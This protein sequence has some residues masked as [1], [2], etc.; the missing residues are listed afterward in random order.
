MEVLLKSGSDV[1]AVDNLGHDAYHYARHCKNAEVVAMVKSCLDKANRGPL[2]FTFSVFSHKDRKAFCIVKD[3]HCPV[4]SVCTLKM[5]FYILGFFF[6][7]SDF[8]G[9]FYFSKN[10]K[11]GPFLNC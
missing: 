5:Y 11:E 6:P 9:I 2:A 4:L 1:K 10:I 3:T 8:V 7:L